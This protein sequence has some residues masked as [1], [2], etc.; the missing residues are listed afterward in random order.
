MGGGGEEAE[1]ESEPERRRGGRRAE[2]ANHLRGAAQVVVVN[3][4]YGLE[5]DDA[6]QL[7]LVFVWRE[8]ERSDEERRHE[9]RGDRENKAARL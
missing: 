2:G 7:G 6:L 4:L 3:L 9:E 1:A 5:V 8:E